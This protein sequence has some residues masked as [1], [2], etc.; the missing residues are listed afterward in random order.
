MAYVVNPV[1][2]GT[3]LL[4]PLNLHKDLC[5]IHRTHRLEEENL[6]PHTVL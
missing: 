6:L 1:L 3:L 2:V 4:K 5:Q